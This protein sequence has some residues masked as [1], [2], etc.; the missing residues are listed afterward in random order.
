MYIFSRL[1]QVV[2]FS[3]KVDFRK[4]FDGHLS[5]CYQHKYNPYEG[6]CVIFMSQDG[7]QI[8]AFFGDEFGLYLVCR[9][10]EGGG[11]KKSL[12]GKKEITEGELSFILQGM[13]IQIQNQ[14]KPWK[15]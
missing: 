10:F 2:I 12:S 3:G 6:D 13:R 14:A 15:K 1:K 7:R 11:L 4:R 9:R 8:R 5:L